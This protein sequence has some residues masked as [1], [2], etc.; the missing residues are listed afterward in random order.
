MKIVLNKA[1]GGYG[2]DVTEKFENFVYKYEGDRTNLELIAFVENNPEDCG[3]LEIVEIPD[4][5]T[6]Y[7]IE[8][9]DGFETLIY[10]VNGKI[11]YE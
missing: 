4:N 8:E 7:T 3:D 11:H 6:D 10:V 1:Y 5:N 9:Y 2:Y